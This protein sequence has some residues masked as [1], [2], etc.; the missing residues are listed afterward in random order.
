MN[1]ISEKWSDVLMVILMVVLATNYAIL[2]L[3]NIFHPVHISELP[4]EMWNLMMMIIPTHLIH[5]NLP[6][7]LNKFLPAPSKDE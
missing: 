1:K 6:S 3:I 5:V 7:V 2:P 4:K